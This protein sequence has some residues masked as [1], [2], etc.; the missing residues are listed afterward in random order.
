MSVSSDKVFKGG[1]ILVTGSS[2]KYG[3]LK[4]VEFNVKGPATEDNDKIDLAENGTYTVGWTA[5]YPGEYTLT[6]KSSDGKDKRSEKVLV[7]DLEVIDSFLVMENIEWTHK[8]YDKLKNEAE[9]VKGHIGSSDD[10]ALDKK[11]NDTKK[12]VDAA[13]KLFE[14]I[15]KAAGGLENVLKKG[16][17]LPPNLSSNLSELNDRLQEQCKQMKDVYQITNREP[18]DNT[19]CEYLV[20]LNEACA[21]FSTFT[22]VWSKSV[23]TVIKNIVAFLKAICRISI[24]SFIVIV[25]I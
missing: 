1:M 22:N 14:E 11:I 7:Y 19:I 15:K 9:R 10:A 5:E 16:A 8:T 3:E 13:I 24:R 18:Y 4:N 6:V 23:T 12:N 25:I 17:P 21:A 20:M 2:V